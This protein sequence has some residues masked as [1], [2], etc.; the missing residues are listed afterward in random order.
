MIVLEPNLESDYGEHRHACNYWYLE[1][2]NQISKVE[3][4]S[5]RQ[6]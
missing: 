6:I 4:Q 1:G 3:E 5:I 2:L